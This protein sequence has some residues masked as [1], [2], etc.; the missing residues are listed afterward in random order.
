MIGAS[1]VTTDGVTIVSV[2]AATASTT[3]ATSTIISDIASK[4]SNDTS[5]NIISSIASAS[6]HRGRLLLQAAAPAA[7]GVVIV[8]TVSAAN[9]DGAALSLA[10]VS[11]APGSHHSLNIIYIDP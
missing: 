6:I 1:G 5:I 9:I 8:Y 3:S 10:L 4:I 2:S 7:A 11:S